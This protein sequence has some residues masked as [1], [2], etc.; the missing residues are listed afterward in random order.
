MHTIM[1]IEGYPA[2]VTLLL[3]KRVSGKVTKAK[4]IRLT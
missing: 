1:S 4:C 2:Q 3:S